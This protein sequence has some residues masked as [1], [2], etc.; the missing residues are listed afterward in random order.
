MDRF[1]IL[2]HQ[3]YQEMMNKVSDPIK[4]NLYGEQKT[5]LQDWLNTNLNCMD[6]VP[7]GSGKTFLASIALPIFANDPY[8]HKGKDII[9]SAP[10]REMIKTLMWEPLKRACKD[11]FK[12]PDNQIN[13]GDL[14]IK[15]PSGAFIRCKSAEQKE[16]LRGINAGVWIADEAALYSQDSLSEISNRLRPR[17]GD[18]DS[19]GR[20]IVISTPNGTNALYTLY[21][22]A[23]EMPHR[24]K[25]RHLTYDQM[26]SGNR[27]FIENQRKILSPLKFAL[28]YQCVWE[29]VEDRFF[30]AWNNTM[31]VEEISDRAG[32]LY[33]FHD[34]NMKRMS[35]IVVQAQDPYT[36]S[37]HIEVLKVYAIPNCSTQQIAETI[38]TDFPHR[39]I[40]SIIDASGAHNNRSTTSQFG[41]TD[42]TILEQWGFTV[43][44]ENRA[45]PLI[46]DTDNSSNAFIAAG[47]LLLTR[48][49]QLLIEALENFHYED[50]G[51]RNLVKYKEQQFA[52]IDAL[53][54][55]LRYGI[56]HLFPLRH[57]TRNQSEYVSSST[58]QSHHPGARFL[59]R[60][61]AGWGTPT[62]EEIF[63]GIN[64]HHDSVSY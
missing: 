3:N 23:L 14:T 40:Y 44:T 17:V 16:A 18:S 49:H 51:R 7:V 36:T 60:G 21:R 11:Y 41:V 56:H 53:G 46:K 27:E 9:Y 20:M 32:D 50:A 57:I 5:I 28:D 33:S 31:P 30:M 10:T 12:I 58:N 52:H 59:K 1:V 4:I 25:I 13:N 19:Q 54:D 24:W 64:E 35:A 63:K 38:R 62:W 47:K 43:I 42:R 37:G 26:R 29:S 39:T 48:E 8:Y 22:A 2:L 55:A 34:F 45:N 6:I 61:A 15:F